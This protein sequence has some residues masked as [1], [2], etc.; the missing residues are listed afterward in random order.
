MKKRLDLKNQRFG[1]LIAAEYLGLK[2]GY[3][4]QWLCRCDCG[5]ETIVYTN[6]LRRGK[7]KS[8]GC[9]I[10]ESTAARNKR[11]NK[12]DLESNEYGT[13]YTAKNQI[14]TFDKEDYEK[15]SKYSWAMTSAGYIVSHN[16]NNKYIR[17][18]RIVM[19]A[20]NGQIID[21]INRN[22]SDNRK[23]N[24]R[25]CTYS[26]NI[27]NSGLRSNNKTGVTGVIYG[28]GL[29]VA[30]IGNQNK[31]IRLGSYKNKESAVKARKK[32]E[33]KYCGEF[34]PQEAVMS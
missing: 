32:A 27:Y 17:L 10:G 20:Q 34:I 4:T 22:K 11:Y 29:W 7:T 2:K 15:I 33:K 18:H 16:E 1:K 3:G 26:E 12:Y 24:L 14:F 8:C 9:Y 5:K 21:H 13:G 31:L 30:Y 19:D 28:D 25:F 23:A 6:H